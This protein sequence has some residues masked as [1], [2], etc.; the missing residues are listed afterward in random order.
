[1]RFYQQK[2]VKVH[3]VLQKISGHY[4][5]QKSKYERDVTTTY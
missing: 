1:M 4:S 5:T 2:G 3:K